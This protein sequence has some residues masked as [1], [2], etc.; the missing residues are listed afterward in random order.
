MII[1]NKLK[2]GDIIGVIA[3]SSPIED[4]DI[5]ELNNS[6]KLLED[7]G[8]KV[9]FADNAYDCDWGYCESPKARAEDI[10]K[11]LLQCFPL[12]SNLE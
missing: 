6:I 9:I 2:K 4:S 10:N 3:P 12:Q 1:P 11:H 8:F 7:F 5:Q